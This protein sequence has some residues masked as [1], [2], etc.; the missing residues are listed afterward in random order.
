[1]TGGEKSPKK[2]KQGWEEY[3]LRW[4][5]WHG[6]EEKRKFSSGCLCCH[7]EIK[8]EIKKLTRGWMLEFDDRRKDCLGNLV[9]EYTGKI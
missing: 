7:K 1:M 9:D 8:A 4:V 3:R 2:G 5:V 6:N